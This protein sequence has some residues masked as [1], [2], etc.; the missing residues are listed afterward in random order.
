MYRFYRA[1]VATTIVASSFLSLLCFSSIAVAATNGIENT[2][3][4]ILTLQ[5]AIKATLQHNPQLASYEFRMKAL[6]GE[7]QNAGLKPQLQ[8]STQLEN[9]A[10]TGEFTGVKTGELTLALSS[11]LELGGQRDAR[12]GVVTARQQQLESS[13]RVLT[14]D[15]LTQ[16]TR[17]FIK[18]AE[19]QE[20]AVL[21]Q[22]THQ[23]TKNSVNSLT[24]Q[25][26]AGRT[27]EAE[28]W[29]AKA[30]LARSAIE[31]QKAEK[32]FTSERVLLSAFWANTQPEFIQIQA[33]LFNFPSLAPL[34]TLIAQLDNNPDIVA[35]G[36]EINL[37]KAEIRQAQTERKPKL[38]WNAGVRRLQV[39][40]DSALVV[41]MS[42]PLGSNERAS[43]AIATANANQKNAELQQDNT[44]IQ[45][46]AQLIQLYENYQQALS[47]VNAL[48]TDV[49]P[50]LQQA[51]RAT[52]EAFEQ[53]RYSY[54]EISLAQ[55]ELLDAQI[56]LITAAAYVHTLN[57]D[58]E[59]LTASSL[60]AADTEWKNLP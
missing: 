23:L 33:D 25:V 2:T 30:A 40:D 60:T 57:T 27:P 28:L 4:K 50:P 55:R 14:L 35:L 56:S 41:G 20:Q 15:V 59:R 37:R 31:V 32:A 52:T 34:P 16:V 26:Q 9:V 38:E 1:I 36:D 58:I 5:D 49:L 12:L 53:G 19:L 18:L 10:G 17:Q 39:S 45:L 48:R 42:V 44:R 51:M 22:Q 8:I 46:H 24:K 54:L 3:P 29:R 11:V 21:L 6:A 13:Q 43:G 47:E 7:K